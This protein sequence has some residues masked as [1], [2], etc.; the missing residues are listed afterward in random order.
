MGGYL[1]PSPTHPSMISYR[2]HKPG[3]EDARRCRKSTA[4]NDKYNIMTRGSLTASSAPEGDGWR[5]EVPEKWNRIPK[6]ALISLAQVPL[7]REKESPRARASEMAAGHSLHLALSCIRW[8]NWATHIRG[9][10]SCR[11][12]VCLL[13]RT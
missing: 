10:R 8:L 13:K 9:R 5:L 2:R 12:L 11:I 1:P 7:E 3:Q 6:E 4:D